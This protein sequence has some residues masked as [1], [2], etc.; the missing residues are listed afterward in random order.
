[1]LQVGAPERAVAVESVRL[2]EDANGAF[3]TVTLTRSGP[4]SVLGSAVIRDG[5]TEIGALRDVS[6]L[7]PN[8]RRTF[9]VRL[10][11]RPSASAR[12]QFVSGEAADKDAVLIDR[13][14]GR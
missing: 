1:V 13:P 3:A 10:N 11:A 9:A 12:L 14:L 2:D 4:N 5:A 6:I 8:G 7:A